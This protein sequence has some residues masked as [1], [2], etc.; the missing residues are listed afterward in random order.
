MLFSRNGRTML[1]TLA[2]ASGAL[3]RA[4]E[5]P[6]GFVS[7]FRR[8]IKW[9]PHPAVPNGQ[10]AILIG[11]PDKA[12]P[13]VL[14]VR[15]PANVRIMPHTHPEARTYTVLAG[16]WKLGFGSK[17]DAEALRDFPAGSVY[18]LPA[19]VPHFQATGPS[20][21][22]VQIESL[23]PTATNFVDAADNAG[24]R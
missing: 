7:V 2:L 10:M 21:T 14:R 22:I 20:E 4:E 15:Y 3:V 12:G 1:V 9:L 24:R 6:A 13:V 18:R 16:E 8:D 17:Y 23:G 11:D 19:K 5:A